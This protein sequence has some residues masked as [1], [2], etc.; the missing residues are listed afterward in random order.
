MTGSANAF[1]LS[2]LPTLRPYFVQGAKFCSTTPFLEG[3]KFTWIAHK[4]SS[5]HPKQ[6][7]NTIET[8]LA[9]LHRDIKSQAKLTA[10][11]TIPIS[12]MPNREMA[13]S[14][15]LTIKSSQYKPQSDQVGAPL[16]I[17][18]TNGI[19]L[20]E[21]EF[22]CKHTYCRNN[23]RSTRLRKDTHQQSQPRSSPQSLLVIWWQP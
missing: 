12:A 21:Q 8:Y 20:N 5:Q 3:K 7:A 6:F 17:S 22:E 2:F 13:T 18:A 23:Q 19:V 15:Q 16:I 1:F 11:L 14:C 9:R 4:A 10:R